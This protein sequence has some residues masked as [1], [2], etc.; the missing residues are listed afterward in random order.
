MNVIAVINH[1]N[2][3][4]RFWAYEQQWLSYYVIKT[5][6][7]V[8][9]RAGIVT[10]TR[11]DV[12]THYWIH[13]SSSD[14]SSGWISHDTSNREAQHYSL[15]FLLPIFIF[16]FFFYILLYAQDI[17]AM[18]QQICKYFDTVSAFSSKNPKHGWRFFIIVFDILQTKW[19]INN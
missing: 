3:G 19:L 17:S 14:F 7:H 16:L 12:T 1:T 6:R 10:F 13:T 5:G 9:Y 15:L 8:R 2:E 4:S 11:C 18:L